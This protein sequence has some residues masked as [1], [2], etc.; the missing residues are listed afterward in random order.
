MNSRR[1]RAGARGTALAW[2]PAASV[3]AAACGPGAAAL[4]G[5]QARATAVHSDWREFADGGARLLRERGTLGGV[6]LGLDGHCGATAWRLDLAQAEGRRHYEGR[7]NL[8]RQVVS[9]A[10]V[11]DRTAGLLLQREFAP[12]QLSLGV[13]WR[14]TRRAL[15]SVGAVQGYVEHYRFAEAQLGLGRVFAGEGGQAWRLDAQAGWAPA[16][17]VR[18]DRPGRDRLQLD[19]GETWLLGLRLGW[20]SPATAL[21]PRASWQVVV[22]ATRRDTGAGPYQAVRQQGALVGTARQP[23]IRV[24]TAGLQLG[25]HWAL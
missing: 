18:V 22:D 12:L 20:S 6:V 10:A 21:S 24:D 9:T 16:G 3:A 14:Q 7:S 19:T 25:L 1:W 17:R 5:L 13:T 8:G 23:R 11:V 4:P 2:L 15:A